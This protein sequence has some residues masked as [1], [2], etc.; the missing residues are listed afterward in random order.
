MTLLARKAA[1]TMRGRQNV[2][3]GRASDAMSER[4]CA[5]VRRTTLE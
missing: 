3:C 2:A 4:A 1:H 5:W